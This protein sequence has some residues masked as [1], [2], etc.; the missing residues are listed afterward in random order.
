MQPPIFQLCANDAGVIALIGSP[1]RLFSFGRAVGPSGPPP[2]KPYAVWQNVGGSPEN[3]LAGRP[4]S[5]AYSI[6]VDVYANTESAAEEVAKAIS[7]AVELDAYVVGWYGTSR[8][9]Q[10]NDYRYSF[11]IDFLVDR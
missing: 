5:D 10:T 4:D 7:T 8:D 6:Q 1:P 2:V 11:A 9:P 3:Y